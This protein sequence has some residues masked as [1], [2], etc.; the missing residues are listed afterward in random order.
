M[1][2]RE[3]VDLYWARSDRAISETER[4][5]GRYCHYIAYNIL[6]NEEDSEECVNDTYMNAWKTIPPHR[7]SLLKTF[8]GKLTRNISI[9]KYKSLT[10]EKRGRGDLPMVLD[11]LHETLAGHE[12]TESIV[13][14]MVL[15]DVLNSFL[16]SMSKEK[17]MIFMRRYWYFSSIKEIARDFNI[18]E[19]KVKM[20]LL[21]SRNELRE[22]LEKEGIII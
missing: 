6:Y 8:L 14:D 9:N 20:S 1:E 4:K 10:A 13:E 17:R 21:R 19:S 22:L 7:P 16:G 11:E 2:D 15:I 3:I 18:G 5:Y 12:K